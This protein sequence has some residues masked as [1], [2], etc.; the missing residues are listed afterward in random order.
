M[1]V[2]CPM[3]DEVT[4]TVKA[5][6][7]PIAN[8][9][10]DQTVVSG[11]TVELDGS[12]SRDRDGDRSIAVYTWFTAA[13][14]TPEL[15]PNNKVAKPTLTAPTV[16]VGDPPVKFSYG[17]RVEDPDGGVSDPA[18]IVEI[19]VIAPDTT[20]PT[21]T[22]ETAPTTHDGK[23]PFNLAVVFS[24]PVVGFTEDDFAPIML[25]LPEGPQTGL[26]LLPDVYKRYSRFN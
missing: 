2:P 17:L 5:N 8:A 14:T 4:I 19:T 11:A 21:G 1:L 9:G 18:D 23:T 26:R 13:G 22:F 10:P 25:E 7:L 16:N 15:K 20:A 12:G 6:L 3:T 24:E